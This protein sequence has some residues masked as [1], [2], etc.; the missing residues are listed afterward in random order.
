VSPRII[1]VS[2]VVGISA[3][4]LLESCGNPTPTGT[5]TGTFQ[6]VTGGLEY[7]TVAGAGHIIVRQ[8]TRHLADREVSS[9]STFEITLPAGSYQISS[10]CVQSHFETQL[11]VPKAAIVKADRASKDNVQCFLN[12]TTG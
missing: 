12:P 10:T 11:S 9:G 7:G 4:T 5:L 2:I 1:T 6:I 8:G 3:M